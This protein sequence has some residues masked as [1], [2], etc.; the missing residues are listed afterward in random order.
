[1]LDCSRQLQVQAAFGCALINSRHY[2]P[3]TG[4]AFAPLQASGHADTVFANACEFR[5]PEPKSGA[6][7]YRFD[8]HS[9]VDLPPT[10]QKLATP[11][12]ELASQANFVNGIAWKPRITD[13]WQPNPRCLAGRSRERRSSVKSAFLARPGMQFILRFRS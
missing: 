7:L 6:G 10:R 11:S 1:M 12:A 13:T 9:Q 8:K 2:L 3:L 5:V 4:A